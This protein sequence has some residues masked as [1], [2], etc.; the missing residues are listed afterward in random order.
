MCYVCVV[1][2]HSVATQINVIGIYVCVCVCHCCDCRRTPH[3]A[4]RSKT[5]GAG[6][7]RKAPHGARKLS[8]HEAL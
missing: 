8:E 4:R 5:R 2:C 1:T 3:A 6:P 7:S